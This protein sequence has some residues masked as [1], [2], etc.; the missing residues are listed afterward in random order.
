MTGARSHKL[1][2]VAYIFPET[3]ETSR[4]EAPPKEIARSTRLQRALFVVITNSHL[5]SVSTMSLVQRARTFVTIVRYPN[6]NINFFFLFFYKFSFFRVRLRLPTRARSLRNTM[7]L[8]LEKE[9]NC[10]QLLIRARFHL[11][12]LRRALDKVI[13]FYAKK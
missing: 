8:P 9:Q 3:K 1:L 10:K 11:C 4:A 6:P 7:I 12:S 2:R 13:F 5:T